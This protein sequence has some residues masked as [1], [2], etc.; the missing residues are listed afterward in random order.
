MMVMLRCA[1]RDGQ[2]PPLLGVGLEL[3]ASPLQRTGWALR[4]ARPRRVAHELDTARRVLKIEAQAINDV[5]A[6]LDGSLNARWS[7]S[8]RARARG[9]FWHGQ[10]G[11]GARKISGDAFQHRY[12]FL[13][14]ASGGGAA[15]RFGCWRAATR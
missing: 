11:T 15:R 6:R 13:F 12:T 3:Q 7:C 14:S 10:V 4:A 2:G 1:Y 8:L 9:A 5:L